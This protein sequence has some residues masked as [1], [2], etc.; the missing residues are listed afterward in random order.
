[1]GISFGALLLRCLKKGAIPNP[2]IILMP[3]RKST[4]HK[5]YLITT[6]SP[7]TC[8]LMYPI[9]VNIQTSLGDENAY[10]S[11]KP[12][13]T[14]SAHYTPALSVS[15]H[16]II[17]CRSFKISGLA[18]ACMNHFRSIRSARLTHHMVTT[19]QR[20]IHTNSSPND[21]P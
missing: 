3:P 6:Q 17:L 19:D 18:A 8:L 13:P 4:K 12:S 2:M 10:A 20:P 14:A 21:T 15:D 11:A 9:V 7:N 1:M 5:W 16:T